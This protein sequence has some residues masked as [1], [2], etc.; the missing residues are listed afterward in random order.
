MSRKFA[1]SSSLKF[2]R[3]NIPVDLLGIHTRL[4]KYSGL[5]LQLTFQ[6]PTATAAARL[7]RDLRRRRNQCGIFT[8]IGPEAKSS[9]ATLRIKYMG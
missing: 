2:A 1:L 8:G 3:M 4:L 6:P 7:K 9:P 5:L